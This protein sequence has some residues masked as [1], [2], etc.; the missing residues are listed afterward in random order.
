MTEVTLDLETAGTLPGSA[1]LSIG[2]VA[3]LPG[4]AADEMEEF[5]TSIDLRTCQAAG[6]QIS[7]DTFGWWLQQE[8]DPRDAAFAGERTLN[9]ALLSFAD[10]LRSVESR[11]GVAIYGKGPSFDCAILASAYAATGQRPPWDYRNE[12]CVRTVMAEARR[13]LGED[14]LSE[15]IAKPQMKHH[16]LHDARA[17]MQTLI[18]I[19]WA[20]DRV[21]AEAREG[22]RS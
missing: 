5:Y 17:E 6:L 11:D 20:I 15:L 1:I 22:V 16:A 19:R 10:W 3:H 7:A 2:A 12:R 8:W 14:G 13:I 9:F 21:V 18:N 4:R